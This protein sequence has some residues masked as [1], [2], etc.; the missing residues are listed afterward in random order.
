MKLETLGPVGAQG[1]AD[2]VDDGVD[3]AGPLVELVD[4][5]VAGGGTARELVLAAL[6][7]P[8][9][10]AVQRRLHE[11]VRRQLVDVQELQDPVPIHETQHVFF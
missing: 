7:V 2:V 1:G 6:A 3:A 9:V 4:E 8:V 11:A 10:D 5:G